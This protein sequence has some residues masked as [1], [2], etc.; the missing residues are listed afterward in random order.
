M[1]NKIIQAMN[2]ADKIIGDLLAVKA[3]EEVL[4]AIDTESDMRMAQAFAAASQKCGADFMIAMMAARDKSQ[5][6][7]IPKS[8]EEA[9]SG[10]DVFIPMTKASGAPAYNLKMKAL[11]REKKIRECCMVLRDIDNYIH[12]GALADYE[13]VYVDGQNLQKLWWH[14]KNAHVTSPAG[15]DLT[16]EM[17]DMM[18][19]IE[20]GIA[21]E[22]GLSMAFSDGEVSLG[23]VE[24][25]MN[26]TMVIDGPMCYYGLPS[27]PV[28][29]RIENGRV[30]EILGGD[31]K[32]C[33]ELEKLFAEVKN[34][35]NIAE[36]GIGL[37]PASLFNGD[38]EEEKKARGTIH[39]ALGNGLYYDQSVDSQVHIDMVLYNT[40]VDFDGE[41]FVKDGNVIIL[42]KIER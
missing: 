24:G 25:T 10:C 15:T 21:R 11:L 39:F 6:T 28:R 22:P 42:D 5:A 29:L 1:D 16:F 19:I 18:P 27:T 37:N 8:L 4:I 33:K 35:D 26:G 14:K 2:I 7:T 31:P 3:G 32:I 30:A 23:P 12:G 20:C 36:I 38:F 34:S 17:I 9:M 40:T 13:Q 41:I